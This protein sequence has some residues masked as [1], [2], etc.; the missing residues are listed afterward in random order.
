MWS[1]EN[2][3]RRCLIR[4]VFD[5]PFSDLFS[6]ETFWLVA[7]ASRLP[8]RGRESNGSNAMNALLHY[9]T[10]AHDRAPREFDGGEDQANHG[11]SL[12]ATSRA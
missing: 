3:A 6:N 12:F 2:Y 7:E 8:P 4:W 5:H 1:V 10:S 9:P 11:S